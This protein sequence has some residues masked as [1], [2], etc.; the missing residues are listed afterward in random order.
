M[1]CSSR[2]RAGPRGGAGVNLDASKSILRLKILQPLVLVS[3]LL[4]AYIV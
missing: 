3:R 2:G 4:W 1:K